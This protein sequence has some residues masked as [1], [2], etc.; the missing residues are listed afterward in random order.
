MKVNDANLQK[1]LSGTN[2]WGDAVPIV[3]EETKALWKYWKTKK[4]I[5]T[6]DDPPFLLGGAEL[7]E[8]L[9]DAGITVNDIGQ[10][11]HQYQLGRYGD[12]GAYE[13]G[14]CRFITARE[15][16]QEKKQK[17]TIE[18]TLADP[19]SKKTHTPQGTF[20]SLTEASRKV[21]I[22]VGTLYKRV[23]SHT[24]K[25]KEYYYEEA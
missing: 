12:T 11:S 7:V 13:M 16:A 17:P 5:R 1:H 15:N 2:C 3:N 24:D 10:R 19:S 21:G 23:H 14:N 9:N 4:Q 25:M 22:P 6:S 20:N 8:L 18:R